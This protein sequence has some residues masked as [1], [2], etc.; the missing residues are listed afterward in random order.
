ME[1]RDQSALR[2]VHLSRSIRP[3]EPDART[4]PRIG[5]VIEEVHAEKPECSWLI[6][7][8]RVSPSGQVVHEIAFDSGVSLIIHCDTFRISTTIP[9]KR[10]NM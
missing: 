10:E 4:A 9:E 5:I 1:Q 7:E 3:F 2:V 8:V 6:D